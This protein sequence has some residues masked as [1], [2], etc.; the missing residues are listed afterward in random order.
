[1]KKFIFFL[2]FLF[3]F[4]SLTQGIFAQESDEQETETDNLAQELTG[5]VPVFPETTPGLI[6]VEGEQAVITNFANEAVLDYSSSG[7]RTLQLNRFTELPG[8]ASFFAEYG[9]YV[10]EDGIYELWYGGT[11]AGPD[12]ILLPSYASPFDLYVNGKLVKRVNRESIN[13]VQGYTPNNYWNRVL[14]IRFNAGSHRI[15]FEI[16]DKRRFDGKFLFFLDAFFLINQERFDPS[17]GY[18]PPVFPET[19]SSRDIDNPFQSLA[20]YELQLKNAPSDIPLHIRVANV[21]SM[22]G[23]YANA[24]K[25]LTK[26]QLL[27]PESKDVLLLLSKNYIWRGEVERGLNTYLEYLKINPLG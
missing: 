18:V 16:R 26:A 19:R 21:Y 24:I 23:D 17:Q 8:N 25:T 11:P 9:V 13:V 7:Q 2:L 22:V 6:W 10:P 27:D 12:D 5:L 1:M 20:E 3:A 4:M 15:R 14:P